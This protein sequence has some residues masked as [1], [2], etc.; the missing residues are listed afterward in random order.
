MNEYN[1]DLVSWIDFA[2]YCFLGYACVNL[3]FLVLIS[4]VSDSSFKGAIKF[5]Q[6]IGLVIFILRVYVA[7]KGI[8]L[9]WTDEQRAMR[10]PENLDVRQRDAAIKIQSGVDAMIWLGGFIDLICCPCVFG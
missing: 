7:I 1:S 8:T 2:I 9:H 10:L 6:F 3:L 4:A 5:H